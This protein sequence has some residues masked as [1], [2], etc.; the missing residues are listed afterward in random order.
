MRL[1]KSTV[2]ALVGL[3]LVFA[4]PL[5][6]QKEG[7]GS[8]EKTCGI[9]NVTP[10]QTAKMQRLMLEHQKAVLPL[11]SALKTKQLE[12][13]QMMIEKADQK[14]LEAKIDELAKAR[15]DIQKKCL[16]QR[17]EVRGLLT[18]EQKKAFDQKCAGMGCG[19]GMGHGAGCGSGGCSDHKMGRMGHGGRGARGCGSKAGCDK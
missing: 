4:F 17:N 10:E 12:L 9:P 15:A 7:A 11:R 6:A 14:S 2:T 1:T 5:L 16:A 18:D 3:A 13:R 19:A 8:C